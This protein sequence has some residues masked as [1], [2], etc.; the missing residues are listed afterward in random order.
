VTALILV[1]ALAVLSL[2]ISDSDPWWSV[3]T[4]GTDSNLRGVSVVYDTVK[5]RGMHYIIWASGSDGAILRSTNDGKTWIQLHVPGGGDLDFR[6]IEAADAKTA[7]VMSSGDG[8]KSRIYKT[9]DGGEN[10]KLQYSDKRKGFF[11]DSLACDSETHCLALSDPV[12]GKFLVLSTTDGEHW[13]E[14]PRGQMPSALPKEGAFAASGTSIAICEHTN[15]Y[16]GTGGASAARVFRSQDRGLSWKA[17]E[18]PIAAGNPSSGIFSI[19]CDGS[20]VVAVGGDYRDPNLAKNVAAYS[21]DDGATW[22]LAEQQ[23]GGY[24]SAVATFSGDFVTVGTNGTDIHQNAGKQEM[25]WQHTDR[26]NLNAV[27]FDGN[28]AWGVGPKGKIARFHCHYQY[29][30]QKNAQPRG[31]PHRTSSETI[32]PSCFPT[33]R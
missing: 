15:F 28:Q 5:E 21:H 19:A 20:N 14:L 31:K 9:T 7:Y 6:D 17:F 25:R 22:Q 24:R 10:W 27:A 32:S 12:D 13:V 4:S 18:T 23:P 30:V 3:Q 26:L 8:G 16:F 11:L 33:T 2:A 1:A 29:E